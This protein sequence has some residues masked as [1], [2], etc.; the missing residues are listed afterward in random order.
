MRRLLPP[1]LALLLLSTWSGEALAEAPTERLRTFFGGA[2]RALDPRASMTPDERLGTIRGMVRDV[3]DFREAAKLSLGQA[4]HARTAGE[5][6]EFVGLFA[7]LLEQSL[8][9]GIAGRISFSEGVRVRYLGESVEGPAATVWTTI[10]SKAGQELPFTYRM[11]E[12]AG[13]WTIRDVA[14]DGVSVAANYRAQFTRV[15]GAGTYRGLVE[16]MRARLTDAASAPIETAALVPDLDAPARVVDAEPIAIALA[17]RVSTT[18]EP[19]PAEIVPDPQPAPRTLA[20][21]LTIAPKPKAVAAAVKPAVSEADPHP[22]WASASIHV[23]PASLTATSMTAS[24]STLPASLAKAAA[25]AAMRAFPASLTPPAPLAISPVAVREAMTAAVPTTARPGQPLAAKA[26][27]WVQVG[28][29]KSTEMAWRLAETLAEREP[30]SGT[31]AGVIVDR[32]G[33]P[34]DEVPL[35]RVRIGPF[36]DRRAANAKLKEVETLVPAPF[37]TAAGVR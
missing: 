27:F 18:S 1:V 30:Q 19:T 10:A 34:G 9:M 3:V 15:L 17:P 23:V 28:A 20:L 11:I 21:E 37:V 29:F 31:P 14:I 4:W 13:R 16:Q 8:I 26:A 24:L 6:D 35:A 33:A 32:V 12:R 5:R 2:A 25:P 7:G 22:T 36:G